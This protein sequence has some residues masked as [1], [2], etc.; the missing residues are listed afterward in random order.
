V[1]PLLDEV[2]VEVSET[3]AAC[4]VGRLIVMYVRM[5]W[6][7]VLSNDAARTRSIATIWLGGQARAAFAW[8]FE[9]QMCEGWAGLFA[10]EE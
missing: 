6:T 10:V 7:G 8:H 3:L 9:G 4:F 2:V 5:R 1:H